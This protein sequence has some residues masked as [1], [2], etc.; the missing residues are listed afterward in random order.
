MN[1]ISLLNKG[2]YFVLI[3]KDGV[4]VATSKLVKNGGL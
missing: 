3:K 1:N 2:L 4:Q